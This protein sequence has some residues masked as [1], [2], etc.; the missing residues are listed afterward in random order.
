VNQGSKED[1]CRSGWGELVV[2]EKLVLAGTGLVH[3]QIAG[4]AEGL[5]QHHPMAETEEKRLQQILSNV[6]PLG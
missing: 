4:E 6:G 5:L 1:L 3:F 2:A